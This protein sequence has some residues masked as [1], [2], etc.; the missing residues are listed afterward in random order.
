[1]VEPCRVAR[2]ARVAGRAEGALRFEH[3]RSLGFERSHRACLI[4]N[5]SKNHQTSTREVDLTFSRML[6]DLIV[7]S[8]DVKDHERLSLLLESRFMS[9]L[10]QLQLQ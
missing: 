9:L 1:M 10:L 7:R 8:K 2:V 4:F 3:Q 5:S 6:A